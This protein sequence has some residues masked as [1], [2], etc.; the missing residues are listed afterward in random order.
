[1]VAKTIVV[2]K[3][4]EI[5]FYDQFILCH[6]TV[7]QAVQNPPCLKNALNHYLNQEGI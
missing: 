7:I 3:Q 2:K 5:G 6:Q 1:M 4:H